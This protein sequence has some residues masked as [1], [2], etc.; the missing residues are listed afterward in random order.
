MLWF[1]EAELMAEY[2]SVKRVSV[3]THR[4]GADWRELPL[5]LI[6]RRGWVPSCRSIINGPMEKTSLWRCSPVQHTSILQ[7]IQ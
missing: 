2:V 4:H 5:W 7:M 3:Q 6:F 1:G